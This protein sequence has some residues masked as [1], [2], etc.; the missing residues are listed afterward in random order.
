MK[1]TIINDVRTNNFNDNFLMQKITGLWKEAS[2]RL[3]NQDIIIYGVYHEY[4]SDYKGDYTLSVAVEDGKSEPSLE[5]TNN[6]KYEIFNV[7]TTDTQGIINTWKK[8]WERENSGTLERAYSYDFEKY[9]PSGEV[10]IYIAI[11]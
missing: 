10:D 4:E 11:K 1:L 3:N 7:D 6:S 9:Y 8:I 5:I 2:N